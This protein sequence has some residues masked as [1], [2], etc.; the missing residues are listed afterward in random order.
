MPKDFI[1]EI[2]NNSMDSDIKNQLDDIKFYAV[3][4]KDGKWFRRKGYG[5]YGGYGET[6]VDDLKSARIYNKPGPARA[7]ISYFYNKWPEYGIAD[8][9]EFSIG[10]FEIIDER[11][12]V[13]GVKKKKEEEARKYEVMARQREIE[14]AKAKLEEAK[15]ELRELQ[16]GED[17][18]D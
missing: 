10:S 9:V 2:D 6:W 11:D 15:K 18:L 3:R 13:L 5:G 1:I 17:G 7:Q 14:M 8:L 16:D 12:R 4:N